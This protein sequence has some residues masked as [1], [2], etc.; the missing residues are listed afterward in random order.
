M[1]ARRPGVRSESGAAVVETALCL[2]FIVLPLVFGTIG[3]AYMLSFRQTVSQS[4]AEGAR[5]AA[6]APATGDRAAAATNAVS[7]SM[8]TGVGGMTCSGG[9]LVK[10]GTAVSGSTCTAS[11]ASCASTAG[12]CVTVTVA[13][14]Y[15]DKSLLPSIPGLGFTLPSR[16]AYSAVAEIS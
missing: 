3:Y 10:G 8:A 4:A 16:V 9:Q 15:R 2:C 14:P 1:V 7:Q 13:Y 11:V 5:A 12:Q 6:V